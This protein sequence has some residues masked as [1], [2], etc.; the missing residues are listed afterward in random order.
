MLLIS[1]SESKLG[2][3]GTKWLSA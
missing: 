3:L 2:K 1:D